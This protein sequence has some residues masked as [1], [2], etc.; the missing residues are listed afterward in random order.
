LRLDLQP[1]RVG[2]GNEVIRRATPCDL[3]VID[4]LGPL[5][6]D[7]GIGMTACFPALEG[8]AYRIA[9][10]VK[11]AKYLERFARSWAGSIT[12]LVPSPEQA[13]G[14]AAEVFAGIREQKIL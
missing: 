5:E 2:L 7:A 9:I 13:A 4:E 6:F 11:R 14:L 3:L 10:A 8:E 12:I 1:S